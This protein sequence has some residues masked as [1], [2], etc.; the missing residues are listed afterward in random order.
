MRVKF[1][2]YKKHNETQDSQWEYLAWLL[3]VVVEG[4]GRWQEWGSGNLSNHV[5]VNENPGWV[6]IR[7]IFHQ[8]S[9]F[10]H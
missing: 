8:V 2:W 9:P 7:G 3:Q 4:S 6:L 10:R 5:E 1:V